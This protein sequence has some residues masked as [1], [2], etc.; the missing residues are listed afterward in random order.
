ME[1]LSKQLE[2]LMKKGFSPVAVCSGAIR[3]YLS[4]TIKRFLPNVPVI[5]YEELPDDVTMQVEG[6]V[7]L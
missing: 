3:P 7:R 1:N 2:T 6:V 5:A 4:E